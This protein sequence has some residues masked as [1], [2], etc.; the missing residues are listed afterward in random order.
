MLASML[1]LV[2][3]YDDLKQQSADSMA[4]QTH[5]TWA[6]LERSEAPACTEQT[7]H[8]STGFFFFLCGLR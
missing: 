1:V 3:V 5:L 4:T 7:P 2:R 8:E 6:G